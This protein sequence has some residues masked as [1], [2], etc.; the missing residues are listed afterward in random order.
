MGLLKPVLG[1]ALS[2]LITLAITLGLAPVADA[3]AVIGPRTTTVTAA[4]STARVTV[5]KPAS[6]WGTVTS[7]GVTGARPVRLELRVASGWRTMATGR[8]ASTGRY[9]M[10]VP[11]GFY[12]SAQMRVSAPAT[13]ATTAASTPGHVLR[14]GPAYRPAGSTAAWAPF[15]RSV[16]YRL[17]PCAIVGYRV[18]L[19]Q[20][21]A[22][23]LADVKAAFA[24]VA[25]ASG[26]RFR[27]RGTTTSMPPSGRRWP[28]DA[29]L[30]VGWARPHQ[31]SWKMSG[32]ILGFGGPVLWRSADDASG[33]VRR[34]ARGGV[35]IDSTERLGR[36]FGKGDLRGKVILHEIGHAI[37]LG[38]VS[39]TAQ[40]M[41]HVI[42]RG[43]TSAWGA[44]DLTGMRRV[45]LLRGCVVTR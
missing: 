31:T 37:G 9:T 17:D 45:G 7:G 38:H 6:V 28:T 29:T 14:V 11:T 21:P 34:I 16:R 18:N 33:A 8:T 23:A 13:V 12:R 1:T 43:S 5:G 24:R 15:S 40:R 42:T 19:A 44:G 22:G 26:L 3:V 27:Y 2:S 30:V 4:W 10:S 25:R 32:S 20:A 41:K 35:L 39:S 36:G